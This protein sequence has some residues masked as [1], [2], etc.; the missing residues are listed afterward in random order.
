M[1]NPVHT[2]GSYSAIAIQYYFVVERLLIE[3]ENCSQ[4]VSTHIEY[5]NV[6]S[7]SDALQHYFQRVVWEIADFKCTSEPISH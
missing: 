1:P 4:N 3:T 5:I 2:V 7:I 6:N